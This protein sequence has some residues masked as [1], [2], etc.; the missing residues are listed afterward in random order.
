[1][2]QAPHTGDALE[3][4]FE[5]LYFL[6]RFEPWKKKGSCPIHKMISQPFH[7]SQLAI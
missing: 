7:G 1:M 6:F 3:T 5:R 4:T 2:A